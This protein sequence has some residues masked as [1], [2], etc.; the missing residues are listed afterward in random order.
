MSRMDW[1]IIGDWAVKKHRTDDVFTY[2]VL[3]NQIKFGIRN[4]K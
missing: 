3:L 2:D 4:T 1:R